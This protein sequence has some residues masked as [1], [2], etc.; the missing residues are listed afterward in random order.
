M[1]TMAAA[2]TRRRY[3]TFEMLEILDFVQTKSIAAA[4]WSLVW[5]AS[6]N[7]WIKHKELYMQLSRLAKV[8]HYLIVQSAHGQIAVQRWACWNDFWSV[9][10]NCI[11]YYLEWS[12][13]CHS[14]RDY[15][16]AHS[17][18]SHDRCIEFPFNWYQSCPVSKWWW[19]GTI[20]WDSSNRVRRF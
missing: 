3:T 1:D 17:F 7:L 10:F 15:D 8:D 4:K 6:I 12:Y 19:T 14:L 11:E 5:V 9:S 20:D 2:R 13:W 18:N 16:N